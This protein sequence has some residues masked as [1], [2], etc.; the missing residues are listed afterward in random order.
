SDVEKVILCSGKLYYDLDKAREDDPALGK[1]T[2][3]IRV[4]Q[5]YPFPSIQLVPYLN[6]YINLKRVIWAQEEPKNM[7]AWHTTSPR[8][9]ELLDQL[10]LGKMELEYV[11]R[12]ERAS[13]ATGSPKAHQREQMEIIQKC[14][15]S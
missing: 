15:S 10:G 7:G 13:P 1:N 4:E 11:G 14:F 8:I 6:G 9:R 3:I 12:T 2:A 5:L